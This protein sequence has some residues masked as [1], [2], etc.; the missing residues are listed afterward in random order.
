[1]QNLTVFLLNSCFLQILFGAFKAPIAID[2]AFPGL[3]EFYALV[4]LVRFIFIYFFS[5]SDFQLQKTDFK[6]KTMRGNSM[7][8][9]G[10]VLSA[11]AVALAATG[12]AAAATL[13][14]ESWRIDDKDL[15]EDVLI[16]AFN[17]SHPAIK[18]KFTPTSPT[19]YDSSVNA[20]LTAGTAGDLITCRPFD[21][22]LNL[23]KQG[24]LE[25]LSGQSSLNLFAPFAKKAWQTDDGQ[26]QFCMPMASVIHGFLYNKEIFSEYQLKE[27][28]TQA[29][30]FAVLDK[31][32]N[33]S[34]YIPIALG[35][36]DQWEANQIVFT[37]VGAN[38]WQGETGRQNLLSGKSSFT[39]QPFV[40]TWQQLAKW[41]DYMGRGYQAQTYSDSQNLF[42]LGRAAIYPT[43]SWDIAYF[44]ANADFELGAFYPPVAKSGDTCYI[45]DHTDIGMG[46]NSHSKNKK[47]AQIFLNWLASAEFAELFTNRVTGFFSLSNHAIDVTDPI[48]KEMVAWRSEC[49]STIRLN[50]QIM[51]RGV[52]NMEQELWVV[53]AQVL[54][55]VLEP[56]EAARR[57]QD[58]FS[59]WYTPQM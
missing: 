22:S 29:E 49:E 42:A 59:K 27:P 32:K 41:G 17:K 26:N 56:E 33:K 34:R 47:E 18:V 44:N 23:F 52:P 36:N 46:I 31:L 38:Y 11:L 58:G 25:D 37:S 6:I 53:N 40:S 4:L 54:N 10:K 39:D 30:F 9:I 16:P 28:K 48:A 57:I 43:G 35:T 55:G 45:S 1:M 5:L 19:E 3:A 7:K 20:R 12:Q 50:A 21:V 8:R 14:I 15:W 51:N 24:N 2:Q 13:T